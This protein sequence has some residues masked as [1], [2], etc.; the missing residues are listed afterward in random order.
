MGCARNFSMGCHRGNWNKYFVYTTT[1]CDHVKDKAVVILSREVL[2]QFID[3][4]G[5][6]ALTGLFEKRTLN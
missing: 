6:K 5:I 1:C 4:G 2:Y 3:L